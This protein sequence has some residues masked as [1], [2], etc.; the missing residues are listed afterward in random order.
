MRIQEKCFLLAVAGF[1]LLGGVTFSLT[2]AADAETP[3]KDC[4]RNDRPLSQLYKKASGIF[5]VQ[6]IASATT[7]RRRDGEKFLIQREPE[8][9]FFIL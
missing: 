2:A 4:A 1:C 7:P 6:R 8:I 5:A 9:F 3:G